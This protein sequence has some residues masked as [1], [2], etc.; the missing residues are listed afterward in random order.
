[1]QCIN[2]ESVVTLAIGGYLRREEGV[3]EN[4]HVPLLRNYKREH[5]EAEKVCITCQ[6]K[7]FE[8]SLVDV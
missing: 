4:V 1:M 5:N 7:V 3:R 2:S 8:L 6:S